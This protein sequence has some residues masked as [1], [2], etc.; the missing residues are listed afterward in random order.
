MLRLRLRRV[1]AAAAVDA[2]PLLAERVDEREG[3]PLRRRAERREHR[4]CGVRDRVLELGGVDRPALVGVNLVEAAAQLGGGVAEV[5]L[6]A[7]DERTEL[8][9]IDLAALV[10]VNL[11]ERLQAREGEVR[12]RL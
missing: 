1:A 11:R 2:P 9:E 5:R 12:W 4:V 3:H 7:A 10:L 6:G 8:F